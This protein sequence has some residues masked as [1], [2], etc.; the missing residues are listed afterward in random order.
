MRRLIERV[1]LVLA[2]AGI[3]VL[4]LSSAYLAAI[5][6]AITAVLVTVDM[7]AFRPIAT[8]PPTE[9]DSISVDLSR[10]R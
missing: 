10:R 8:Q 7:I 6:G 4:C 1:A 9:P 3:A 2:V 5:V